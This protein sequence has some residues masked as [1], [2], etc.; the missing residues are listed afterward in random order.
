MGGA[1]PPGKV[2]MKYQY[3]IALASLLAASVP[4][5]AAQAE[6][7]LLSYEDLVR[8]ARRYEKLEGS[9]RTTSGKVLFHKVRLNLKPFAGGSNAF[10]VVRKDEIEYAWQ[11]C[12]QLI[13]GW[14]QLGEAPKPYTAGSWGP[15]ASVAL[16]TRDGRSWYG[17]L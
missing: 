15:M 8:E 10:Y 14:K 3:T 11:W 9:E 16:I 7:S 12:D 2:R 4:V 6:Q 1:L 17:D 13:A 5:G